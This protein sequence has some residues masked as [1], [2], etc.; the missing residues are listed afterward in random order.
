MEGKLKCL[1]YL[2]LLVYRLAESQEADL[3]LL[4]FVDN[5]T[6]FGMENIVASQRSDIESIS[7]S[8]ERQNVGMV[9]FAEL[10]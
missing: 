7:N 10:K 9:A 6:A 2:Q 4:L 3:N 1:K 5:T 8:G